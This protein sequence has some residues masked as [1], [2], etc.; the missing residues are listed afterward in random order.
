MRCAMETFMK[1]TCFLLIFMRPLLTSK[2][3]HIVPS[4]LIHEPKKLARTRAKHAKNI[5]TYKNN[6]IVFLQI[7]V[8]HLLPTSAVAFF[9]KSISVLS[10]NRNFNTKIESNRPFVHNLDH[11][12]TTKRLLP[13]ARDTGILLMLPEKYNVST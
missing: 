3:A 10:L 4:S 1:S 7:L 12:Y 5:L 8:N 13:V 6:P 2:C 11:P 9:K